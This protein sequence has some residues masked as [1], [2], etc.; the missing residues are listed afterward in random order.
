MAAKKKA[1]GESEPPDAP[2]AD[3]YVVFARRFRPQSFAEVVGQSAV[4]SALRQALASGRLAQAYLL[5]GPRGVGKTS[6][7]RIFAKACNCLNGTGPN[8][9]AEEP[10]NHCDACVSIQEG[11]A[12]DVIEMDAA[13]NR[14]IE[15]VRSL[16]ENVGISPAELRYKIYII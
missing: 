7:A 11:S 6:L 8:G 14:G 9:V 13:T 16:R 4:T 1:K 3:Q 10:C 15:E 2:A 5:C 12:L